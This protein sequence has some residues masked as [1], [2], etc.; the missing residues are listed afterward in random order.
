[1]KKPYKRL[2]QQ[3]WLGRALDLLAKKGGKLIIDNL[4]SD[5]GVTKGSFYWHFKDRDDFLEKLL[6]YWMSEYT[7]KVAV[8]VN[9]IEASP[10]ERLFRLMEFILNDKYSQYDMAV[11]SWATLEPKVAKVIRKVDRLRYNYI[12]NLFEEMG[13]SG[14]ELEMRTSTLLTFEAFQ[15]GSTITS[16]KQKKEARLKLR[17]AFFIRK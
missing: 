9:E 2:T 13:F 7:Q 12:R 15:H 3:Q 16:T 11:R 14:D 10:E 8:L 6:N 5:L 1:M 4:V 17:H